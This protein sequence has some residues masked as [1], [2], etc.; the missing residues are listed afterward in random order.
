[1]NRKDVSAYTRWINAAATARELAKAEEYLATLE[2]AQQDGTMIEAARAHW[3]RKGGN[4]I[5]MYLRN[6]MTID[7]LD[8][9]ASIEQ[10]PDFGAEAILNEELMRGEQ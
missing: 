5:L 2:V 3:L 10:V 4:L 1:M 7:E 8:S 9:Q 6:Q